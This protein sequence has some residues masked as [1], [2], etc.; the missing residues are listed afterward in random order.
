MKSQKQFTL[1]ELLVVIA[2]I[3][4][5]AS[6]LLPALSKAREKAKQVTCINNLKQLGLAGSTYVNDTGYFVSYRWGGGMITLDGIAYKAGYPNWAV[7]L[8]I[9]GYVSY[10]ASDYSKK[11]CTT[12]IFKCPSQQKGEM[13]ARL[14]RLAANSSGYYTSYVINAADVLSSTKAEMLKGVAGRKDN[15]I[16]YPCTT[17]FLADG[18]YSAILNTSS[19]AAYLV[20]ARH[21]SNSTNCVFVD[22]H[23]E[24][25]QSQKAVPTSGYWGYWSSG[26]NP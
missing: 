22:G 11:Y 14:D 19:S 12:G 26:I 7:T 13:A 23:C 18:D 25:I 21:M 2:I 8:G 10:N 15:T 20:A 5:L 24:S 3:A 16:K 6:M 17:I 9:M 4:I 1:I